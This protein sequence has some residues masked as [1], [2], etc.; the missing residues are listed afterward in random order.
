MLPGKR[1]RIPVFSVTKVQECMYIFVTL[2]AWVRW[3]ECFSVKMTSVSETVL[4][5][6]R[7][8]VPVSSVTK[9]GDFIYLSF[10]VDGC[11]GGTSSVAILVGV[12]QSRRGG[13]VLRGVALG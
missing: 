8:R 11:V 7:E 1:K 12:W 9:K 10:Y 13:A 4:Q 2:E 3:G 6:R 5:G